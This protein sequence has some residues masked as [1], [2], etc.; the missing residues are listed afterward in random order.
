MFEKQ[1]MLVFSLVDYSATCPLVQYTVSVN[2]DDFVWPWKET[3]SVGSMYNGP[4]QLKAL[5]K[6]W[7]QTFVCC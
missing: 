4:K 6:F 1:S 3:V 5:Q 2:W 7:T